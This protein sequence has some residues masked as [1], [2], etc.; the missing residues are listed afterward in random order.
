MGWLTHG[1]GW[2]GSVV[3]PKFLTFSGLVWFMHG[4]KMA[5]LRNMQGVFYLCNFVLS[6]DRKIRLAVQCIILIVMANCC[7]IHGRW[8]SYGLNWVM[9]G[10]IQGVTGVTSHPF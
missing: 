5:D 8:V 7:S 3:G 1:L 2:V 4:S 10:R 9:Q 6:V